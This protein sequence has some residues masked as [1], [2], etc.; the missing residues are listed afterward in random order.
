MRVICITVTMQDMDISAAE[1]RHTP[2]TVSWPSPSPR[3]TKGPATRQTPLVGF[4]VTEL[5]LPKV[6]SPAQA[7]EVLRS[8]GL[9]EIT[10]CA[11]RTRAYRKQVPFHL[12]GRRI[13][14][15]ISDLR[16]IAEGQPHPQEPRAEASV[17]PGLPDLADYRRP[18]RR[19]STT[20]RDGGPPGGGWRARR[21]RDL[22][23]VVGEP[24]Q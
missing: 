18:A 9:T 15:T 2:A 19:R 6:F 10:E 13:M 20:R 24:S 8:L 4:D 11:L 7:A 12:N 22:P 17:P 16:A 5:G 21:P 3:T 1:Q 23:T 14:F